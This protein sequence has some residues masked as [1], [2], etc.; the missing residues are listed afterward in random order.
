MTDPPPEQWFRFGP[1]TF[2]VHT[3]EALIAAGPRAE[4]SIDVV[5]WATAYGLTRIDH[6]DR[7]T[8]SLLGPAADGFDR[9]YAM[10]TDVTKP[11]IVA[12][13]GTQRQPFPLLID[14]THRLYRG[15]R[16]GREHLPAY[17][18]TLEESL[19]IRDDVFLGPDGRPIRRPT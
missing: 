11:V 18:L 2:A 17:L 14:G 3:A 12:Q 8:V 6:S 7:R 5:A 4:T 10:T 1:W 16:E 9:A 13:L 15:W 19:Q